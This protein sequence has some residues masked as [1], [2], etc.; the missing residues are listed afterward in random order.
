MSKD[1][2]PKIF[3][4]GDIVVFYSE[5]FLEGCKTTVELL[6]YMINDINEKH[7]A[8]HKKI[9][10]TL[11]EGLKSGIASIKRTDIQK[12]AEKAITGK[13]DE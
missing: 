7:S 1:H 8:K 10:K 5:A 9:L 11:E 3:S 6:H 2:T 4:E 12:I 13:G